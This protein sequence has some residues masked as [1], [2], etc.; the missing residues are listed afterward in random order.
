MANKTVYPFGTGGQL[1][2]SIGIIND[3]TTGGADKA[4][5]AE[6]GKAIG[7]TIYPTIQVGIDVLQ[8]GSHS[9]TLGSDKKWGVSSG[10]HVAMPVLQ[11]EVYNIKPTAGAF[12][13]FV[14][15]SYE[16]PTGTTNVPYVS[17]GNRIWLEADEQT[18]IT[19]PADAAYV[20]F[21]LMGG[22][23]ISISW[24]VVQQKRIDAINELKQSTEQSIDDIQKRLLLIT[25]SKSTDYKEDGFVLGGSKKWTAATGKHVVIPCVGGDIFKLT[26]QSAT[27]GGYYGWLET[28]TVPTTLN[29][30]VPYVSGGDRIWLEEETT[31][32]IE[33]PT[34]AT[35]LCLVT[36]DGNG[37]INTWS[38]E[39][40]HQFDMR[41]DI[42]ELLD[43]SM[44]GL[45][46]PFVTSSFL[47]IKENNETYMTFS[48]GINYRQGVAIYNNF[49]V[50]AYSVDYKKIKIYNLSSKN[51]VQEIDLP[52]F[53]NTRYHCNTISFSGTKYE[54]GDDFPLLY[55][56]SGYTD[57]VNV[58]TSE[59]YV[60]RI[61]GTSGNYTATLIQTITLDFGIVGQ[62]T[63]FVCDP[64]NNRAWITGSGI[65]SIICIQIPATTE[66]SITIDESVELEDGF[67]YTIKNIG[68]SEKSSRQGMCFYKNRIYWASGVLSSSEEGVDSLYIIVLNTLTHCVESIVPLKNYGLIDEPEGCFIWNDDFYVAYRSN[69]IKLIQ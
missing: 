1:P 58:T 17:G 8:F 46:M 59:V 67:D 43:M 26:V 30:N 50:Q 6:M 52:Q 32:T 37:K 31:I 47:P 57:N 63:E 38:F 2:S 22:N 69:L 21:S 25:S 68:T 51:L 20:I 4:L 14:T 13:G 29:E 24:N 36:I 60:V 42:N 5:S 27:T 53:S 34:D 54:Q 61:V 15:S 3:L 41:T 11:D 35:Y 39:R 40:S 44:S 65:K 49:L 64:N 19:V 28:Y 56:C 33:A 9:Y 23:G 45:E 66:S 7:N 62:W 10:S 48:D 18:Q 16:P 12:Y 55:M